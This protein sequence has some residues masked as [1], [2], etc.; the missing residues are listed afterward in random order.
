MQGLHPAD[1]SR[2]YLCI[3][4]DNRQTRSQAGGNGLEYLALR[5]GRNV[6]IHLMNT[7]P[8]PVSYRLNVRSTT[9]KAE[10]C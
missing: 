6:I 1:R 10:G 2:D 9:E 7:E 8:A 4:K 5:D 3:Q